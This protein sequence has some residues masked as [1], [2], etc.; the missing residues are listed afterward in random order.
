MAA[1]EDSWLFTARAEQLPPDGD[2]RIWLI[3]SGRGWGKTR[4][5]AEWVHV[6]AM[7]NPG[8]RIA[9]V[10]R[11]AADARDVM[12]E[13]QSGIL[14]CSGDNRPEY[15]P[16]KRR[17]TWSNGSM[18]STYSADKP[19]Q[20]RGPQ[21]HIAWADELAAWPRWD[22]W[23][24]LQMGLRLGDNPRCIVT[25]TPR[26]LIQLRRLAKRDTTV[27][28]R[29]RT[30][31]N[32][33]NLSESYIE[34]IHDEYGGT[35][36]GRQELEGELLDEMPGA[37]FTRA[38]IDKARV[39][40]HPSFDRIVVAVD[41]AT[42]GKETSDESG[43][44][45]AGV[46]KREFFI[47]ADW[48]LRGSPDKVCRRA[49]E[50]YE[51]FEADR[52]VFEANQGGETW[53]TIVNGINS[54]VATKEVHASRGKIARAEPVSARYE[55]GRVHHVGLYDEL[56]DQM[57]NY[58]AGLSKDSPDRMDALVW[59]I[60]ELDSKREI[61]FDFNPGENFSPQVFF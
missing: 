17:V 23:V 25:T 22:T 40:E 39:G 61:N 12:V 51:E 58:V 36:L 42:T 55:Q 43:I 7:T 48:S 53:R 18:A 41:P 15:E 57:C 13:G 49:V 59:A 3:Q 34:T 45:V 26:P 29:G 44:I 32:K 4:T 54:Q 1:L 46:S 24:Q 14:A 30:M 38:L 31:D 27:I 50:A 10:A 2:W 20:L 33:A 35:T 37:L 9:L 19:D 47:L 56:E 16:S 6:M 8:I 21:H 11:T 5:G 52:I 28:T 60:T